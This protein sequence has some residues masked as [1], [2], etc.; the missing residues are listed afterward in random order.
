MTRVEAGDAAAAA[1]V[2]VEVGDAAAPASH[3]PT[4]SPG[5]PQWLHDFLS[6]HPSPRPSR[7]FVMRRVM[8]LR[9][10]CDGVGGEP[11]VAPS[12]LL[13][14]WSAPT[15]RV[16]VYRRL[17]V[18][19]W[20]ASQRRAARGE[21]ERTQYGSYQ[22]MEFADSR[23]NCS[24][25]A[26]LFEGTEPRVFVHRGTA[27]VLSMYPRFADKRNMELLLYSIAARRL[28][29]LRTPDLPTRGKNW[30]PFSFCT[31]AGNCSVY[32][33]YSFFPFVLLKLEDEESD[34]PSVRTVFTKRG[35]SPP[36]RGLAYRG[37][38]PG[39]VVARRYVCGVGHTTLARHHLQGAFL[40]AFDMR[41]LHLGVRTAR[42]DVDGLGQPAS[43]LT[44]PTSA[45]VDEVSGTV[46][47]TATESDAHWFSS[48]LLHSAS[49][50]DQTH[51]NFEYELQ[52]KETARPHAAPVALLISG[53]SGADLNRALVHDALRAHVVQPLR[54]AGHVVD[55]YVCLSAEGRALSDRARQALAPLRVVY[56]P[57]SMGP[58]RE[59]MA[60]LVDANGGRKL[61]RTEE[62]TTRGSL[63]AQYERLSGCYDLARGGRPYAWFV[64]LR[65]DLVVWSPLPALHSLSTST[66]HV[67]VRSAHGRYD[68][69]DAHFGSN[70]L[71]NQMASRCDGE[72]S[73]RDAI[74]RQPCITADDQFF[75]VPASLARATFAFARRVA[76]PAF[77]RQR[78]SLPMCGC[79]DCA[80]GLM[81]QHLLLEMLPFQPW[82]VNASLWRHRPVQGSGR[83]LPGLWRKTCTC[84]DTLRKCALAE[85]RPN[86]TAVAVA[87]SCDAP[88]VSE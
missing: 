30:S 9:T 33:L 79:W 22:M 14:P 60:A 17:V 13:L 29:R 76:T 58:S 6:T 53:R 57:S 78:R 16:L 49:S 4:A 7:S 37:G 51:R 3:A 48:G 45:F 56:S 11:V 55:A 15:R 64:R 85:A 73:P 88:R 8:R 19:E 25:A 77:H 12:V 38:T 71:I 52:L 87:R 36:V 74:I 1:R 61:T 43:P 84:C 18:R 86:S 80:E 39:I 26:S 28:R 46:H 65:P 5:V 20:E 54:A 44:F 83:R 23:G 47:V 41:R 70:P 35:Q 34:Q 67:R 72:L 10:T 50:P 2:R 40:W 81:T 24:Q 68:L 66:V 32:F 31:T 42:L 69:L 63:F 59:E 62:Q 27:W 82:L 21:K 75:A